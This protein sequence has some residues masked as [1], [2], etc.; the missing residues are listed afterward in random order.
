LILGQ[1]FNDPAAIVAALR[2]EQPGQREIAMYLD[3][4]HIMLALAPQ[5]LFLDPRTPSG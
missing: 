2:D 1:T 3:D 4:P 5:N